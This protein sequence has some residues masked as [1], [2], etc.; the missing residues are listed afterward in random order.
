MEQRTA[1]G[2]AIPKVFLYNS[3][4]FRGYFVNF[5]LFNVI[6]AQFLIFFIIYSVEVKEK[7]KEKNIVKVNVCD[8][9][10]CFMDL[11]FIL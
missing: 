8:F 4:I 10:I 5:K 6:F 2:L 11:F 7:K 3:W 9:F 1:T